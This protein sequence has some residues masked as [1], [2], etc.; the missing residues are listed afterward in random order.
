M[1][2]FNNNLNNKNKKIARLDS[3]INKIGSIKYL[4]AYSKEWNN[5]IYSFNKNNI[6]NLPINLVNINKIIKSYFNL[7]FI[8]KRKNNFLKL[9]YFISL[10]RRRKTLQRIVVSNANIKFTSNKAKVTLYTVNQEKKS[11]AKR[12]HQFLKKVFLNIVR[13]YAYLYNK[14]IKKIGFTN[15]DLAE[16]FS[17]AN[18]TKIVKYFKIYLVLENLFSKKLWS[19]L[20]KIE[21]KDYFKSF[22]QYK[23]LYS[24]N[25][26][27]FNK[28]SLLSKLSFLL[29]KFTGKK[30][31]Y[32]IVNLKSFA[33]NPDILTNLLVKKIKKSSNPRLHISRLL[34]LSANK[35]TKINKFIDKERINKKDRIDF[36]RNK[37][38]DLKVIS[39]EKNI[40]DV[41]NTD[42]NNENRN[43]Y[44]KILNSINYKRLAGI[45]FEVSG[46]LTKRYRADKSIFIK[47]WKGGLRNIYSSYQGLSTI[48]YRG[49]TKSNVSYSFAKSKRRIGSFAVK[50]WIGAK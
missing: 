13:K 23:L 32:N 44:T 18:R 36:F 41:M 39:Y 21:S 33:Y 15:L 40:Y 25:K 35:M 45:R 31:Q 46:R 8:N 38:K 28:K 19:E 34:R 2:I 42:I 27:K 11:L 10:K 9:N 26:F 4:P 47:K 29:Q 37:Y 24:L 16:Y 48:L 12:Y 43:I 22:R 50:G 6:K 30:I 17:N 5:V 1:K 14:Q 49:N 20:I 3:K 7:F